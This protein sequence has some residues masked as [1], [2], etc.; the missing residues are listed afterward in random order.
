[1]SDFALA[2]ILSIGDLAACLI[3]KVLGPTFRIDHEKARKAGAALLVVI[4]IG[5]GLL[6][7][8]LYS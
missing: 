1:M 3:G 2:V 5:A 8:I 4:V 6:V 7:T